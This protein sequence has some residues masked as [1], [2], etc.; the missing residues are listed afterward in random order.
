MSGGRGTYPFAS[1]SSIAETLWKAQESAVSTDELTWAELNGQ[2]SHQLR[3]LIASVRQS[4]NRYIS[5]RLAASNHVESESMRLNTLVEKCALVIQSPESEKR[6]LFDL[7]VLKHDRRLIYWLDMIL[8]YTV[9]LH[10]NEKWKFF[11]T[12]HF[13]ME[14]RMK[15]TVTRQWRYACINVPTFATTF[16]TNLHSSLPFG[17]CWNPNTWLHDVLLLCIEQQLSDLTSKELQE[18]DRGLSCVIAQHQTTMTVMGDGIKDWVNHRLAWIEGLKN[19]HYADQTPRIS[20]FYHNGLRSAIQQFRLSSELSTSHHKEISQS[21]MQ[22]LKTNHELLLNEIKHPFA[23]VQEALT[24]LSIRGDTLVAAVQTQAQQSDAR[25]AQYLK[26]LT[27]WQGTWNQHLLKRAPLAVPSSS[28]PSS[29]GTLD[30]GPLLPSASAPI[31]S[32]HPKPSASSNTPYPQPTSALG[33]SYAVPPVASSHPDTKHTDSYR[34]PPP[35][36]PMTTISGR[37]DDPRDYDRDRDRDLR[38]YDDSHLP[39]HDRSLTPSDRSRDKYYSSSSR[40]SVHSSSSAAAVPPPLPSSS[41][42][43]PYRAS[44]ISDREK[45]SIMNSLNKRP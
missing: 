37:S 8:S 42:Y 32:S 4:V 33:G 30:M 13:Q 11:P 23:Q 28:V 3:L 24:K 27:D 35:G 22:T 36:P 1:T 6:K 44:N 25:F 34:R 20:S 16:I 21:M 40:S 29:G 45:Q 15:S 10:L 9:M 7:I 26:Q 31:H 12:S 5:E 41:S 39:V 2:R 17:L 14:D 18:P 19:Q 43:Q 38:R